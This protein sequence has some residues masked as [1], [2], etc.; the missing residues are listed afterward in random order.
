MTKPESSHSV[1]VDIPELNG[2]KTK[3]GWSNKKLA[4][5]AVVSER[6]IQ[7]IYEKGMTSRDTYAR[8]LQAI[9]KQAAA[10][11]EELGLPRR[12]LNI[13]LE[14]KKRFAVEPKTTPTEY[15][16][17]TPSPS[18]SVSVTTT[19]D[20]VELTI[21]GDIDNFTPEQRD[22]TLRLIQ[23][24]LQR[25]SPPEVLRYRE[26]SVKITLALS[27]AESAKLI[28]MV[29]NDELE[30]HGIINATEPT[31]IDATELVAELKHIIDD[32]TRMP[33]E[34]V[35]A[36]RRLA[37]IGEE[38]LPAIASALKD[39]HP[40][41]RNIAAIAIA[42]I[43]PARNSALPALKLSLKDSHPDVRK[44]AVDAL[45]NIGSQSESLISSAL[46]D[47][48]PQVRR[49][50]AFSLGAIQAKNPT[51]LASA[52]TDI[53]PEVRRLSAEALGRIKAGDESTVALLKGLLDDPDNGVRKA[54]TY[55]LG[56]IG[57]DAAALEKAMNDD[58]PS[59]REAATFALGRLGPQAFNLLTR[60][61]NDRNESVRDIALES[62]SRIGIEPQEAV[63]ECGTTATV[64]ATVAENR[65]LNISSHCNI[66]RC[67][68]E[69]IGETH[70]G[71]CE[72]CYK[73]VGPQPG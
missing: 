47:Q 63:L 14:L 52:L 54:A 12:E 19:T 45:R 6:T 23:A 39:G 43:G 34:R 30:E 18:V 64:A 70:R 36:V 31:P 24:R 67:E 5:Q 3:L 11:L 33:P 65:G 16:G 1:V 60:A 66:C 56:R 9:K 25:K 4:A 7:R 73:E 26:G 22:E 50:A 69:T 57:V 51:P 59:V 28:E 10:N 68:L 48:S 13:S 20:G 37:E 2:W 35:A 72:L 49:A 17:H 8:V 55:T 32:P 46:A 71:T 62:L 27:P 41:V 42:D 61:R 21:L 53:D 58:D 15:T 44:S 40:V 38:A 29:K